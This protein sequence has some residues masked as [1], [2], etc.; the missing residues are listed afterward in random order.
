MQT[1]GS[2]INIRVNGITMCY[3]DLG[4]GDTPIIFIHGFPFDKSSWQPQMDYLKNT[5]RVIAYDIRG[6]GKSAAGDDKASIVLFA[7]DLILFMDA[8]QI[9]K[10]IVCGLSMGGYIL[11]NAA[12]RYHERF[13]AIILSDTQCIA[14]SDEAKEKRYKTIERIEAEGI[15]DFA[16]GF[17]K[18]AFCKETLET[19]PEVVEKIKN[20]ILSTSAEAITGT[21]KALAERW[22][23]C[24]SLSNITVPAL[25]LCGKEDALTPV[26]QS[27][28]LAQ[29]ISGADLRTIDNAGHLSNLEQPDEFNKHLNNFIFS[30]KENDQ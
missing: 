11:L 18:N 20:I 29:N 15:N 27:E 28:Y 19:K 17:V 4:R 16:S 5:H 12:N 23:T 24:S 7:D 21:L 2:D 14:D 30:L 25:V 6:F 8:L 3:D 13:E 22:E 1:T 10:A 9:N 26:K